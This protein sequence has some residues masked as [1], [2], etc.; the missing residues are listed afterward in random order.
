MSE[1]IF[2]GSDHV[3]HGLLTQV[4]FWNALEGHAAQKQ[5][6]VTALTHAAET[7]RAALQRAKA[8]E[9]G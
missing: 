7:L 1:D 6:M 5:V 3:L 4:D 9:A 2:E 8:R